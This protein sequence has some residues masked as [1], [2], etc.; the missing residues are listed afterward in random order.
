MYVEIFRTD[1]GFVYR[2]CSVYQGSWDNIHRIFRSVIAN[3]A[4]FKLSNNLQTV[5][6]SNVVR[7]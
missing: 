5:K 3:S 1:I 7:Y 4:V 6:R 2:E